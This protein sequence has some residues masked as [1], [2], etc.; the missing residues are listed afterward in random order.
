[1]PSGSDS[2]ESEG[3]RLPK[4][5]NRFIN[6]Q[7][8]NINLIDSVNPFQR[9]YEIL[10]KTIDSDTLRII[11]NCVAAQQFDI[12]LE[13]AIE[14]CKGPYQKYMETHGGNRPSV[15]DADPKVRELAVAF[16]YIKDLKIRH[17]KGLDYEPKNA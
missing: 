5:A 6:I 10:S 11:Q 9:A 4:V 3:N 17:Q 8:L 12:S 13:R 15:K 2:E 1:M 14:L 7:D 16:N